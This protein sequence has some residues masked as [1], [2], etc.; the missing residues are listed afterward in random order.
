VGGGA[1]DDRAGLGLGVLGLALVLGMRRRT[2]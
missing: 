2:R 1:R